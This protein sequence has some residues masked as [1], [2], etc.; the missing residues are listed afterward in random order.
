MAICYNNKVKERVPG[1]LT[2]RREKESNR[3]DIMD[4]KARIMDHCREIITGKDE[5]IEKVLI[6]F[7]C[8]GHILLEDLPGTGKTMLLRAFAA[9]IG[10]SF[11]RIQFTP[12]LLPS[13]LTG[14]NFYNQKSGEFEFRPGPV[15]ANMILADEINRATPRTQSSLLEAMAEGQVTVDGKTHDMAE[16]FMIM[17]TQN[18]LETHGTFP[19][20]EAQTDRFFMRLSLGYMDAESELK[21]LMDEDRVEKVKTLPSCVTP[22]ET[23]AA[24]EMVKTVEVTRDVANYLLGIVSATRQDARVRIGVSTRGA[25]ALYR[26]AQARAALAGHAF[27]RP[28]DVKELAPSVLA[29]RLTL[30]GSSSRQEAENLVQE[31]VETVP[32]PLEDVSR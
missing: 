3:M 24:K 15:F 5:V 29:H 6:C 7:L 26:A 1:R 21:V 10:G 17:A 18:P 4:Y 11:R 12:D 2:P 27:V 30:I 8:S 22:E 20:P 13:D 32:V 31:I 9:G 28:E 16:P 25:I 14:I 23:R 19:L